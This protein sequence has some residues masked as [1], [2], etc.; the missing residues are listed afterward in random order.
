VVKTILDNFCVKSGV[1]C[2]R[3]EEK[4]KKGQVS[5]L[6]LK[7]IKLLCEMEKEYA[8]LQDITFNKAIE[9]ENI[10]VI[11]VDKVDMSKI[12]SQGGKIIRSIGERT[13]KRVRILAFGSDERQFLEDLLSPFSILTINTIW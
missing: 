9:V 7:I 10:L 8:P 12:L 5:Q 11:L 4:V 2:P 1:L 13:E 3:C 6:D